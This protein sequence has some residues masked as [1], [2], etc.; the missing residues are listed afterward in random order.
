MK[1]FLFFIS[2]AML[3]IIT[4]CSDD[5]CDHIKKTEPPFWSPVG[6]WYEEAENEEMRFGENGTFYDKYCNIKRSAETEGR[7]EY[8]DEN[9]KLTYNYTSM[10][11]TQFVDWT[12][13]NK[14]ELSFTI[15][16][17]DVATHNL[18]KIVETYKMEVGAVQEIQFSKKYPA[19]SVHSY[20]SNS[21]GIASVTNAGKIKAEGEKG[22]TYI[23]VT[24]DKGNVWV[25]VVVGDDC[26]D[27]WY[28]YSILLGNNYTQMCNIMGG[29]PD[30]VS[31]DYD[32]YSYKPTNHDVVD[33]VNIFINPITNIAEQVDLHLK[34]SV[35]SSQINSYM[36][37]HYYK[38]GESGGIKFYHT[39]PTYEESRAIFA[40]DK[41]SNA[42]VIVPAEG[43][44]DLW[45]DYT[46]LFG[47]TPSDINKEMTNNGFTFLMSDYSYSLDGSDYY[48]FPN[49]NIAS[50][51]GFV[52]NKD[53]EMCEYWVYLTSNSD[54]SEVYSFL[55]SKYTFDENE[56]DS[57]AGK[58]VFYNATRDVRITF[59]L[60][61]S[62]KYEKIGMTGPTKPTGL[63]PDYS[64]DL[65]KS[66]DEIVSEYGDP[67]ID[68]DSGMWYLPV[69]DY[70]NYLIFRLDVTTEKIK[71][72]SLLMKDDVETSTVTDYMESLY[73]AF[74]NGTAPDGSQYAWT[75]GPTTGESTFGII[76]FTDNK[77]LLYQSLVSSSATRQFRIPERAQNIIQI[78][79]FDN[80]FVR[81][82]KMKFSRE[83]VSRKKWNGDG[84]LKEIISGVQK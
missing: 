49:N 77:H 43:F 46:T 22:T 62:V 13:K 20:V 60:E 76:Y 57:K 29:V 53:K 26:L 18:E 65:G 8:D 82:S 52:F 31:V 7:W 67:L 6:S 17:T 81:N 79:S 78:P 27:L 73:Y 4:S 12:V 19:Y 74:A 42:I 83:L 33:Y 38:L 3:F 32:S 61:G 70:I 45:K 55:D 16:S 1:K 54:A 56:S 25:K 34:E 9:S 58:Y 15:S 30:Q 10:G 59:S 24:T 75:N 68:D 36:D 14:K 41:S 69:N 5:S 21:Q 37:A 64:K 11:Q 66:H 63:W 72:I 39:S 47:Q 80:P 50:M 44:L 40:Y 51:V 48:S 35:P 2:A 84:L 71:Y 28:D 23:K